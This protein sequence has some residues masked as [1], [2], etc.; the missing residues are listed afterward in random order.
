MVHDHEDDLICD[1][2]ETYGIYDYKQLPAHRVAILS[3]G[4]RE[5]S[6]I[7][8]K[9]SEQKVSVDTTLLAGIMDRVGLLVWMQ[10]RDGQKGKNKPNSVLDS[11]LSEPKEVDN[12]VYQSGEEFDKERNRL[13]SMLG[14]ND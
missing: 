4:L 12:V 9:M 3:I 10:T 14:G 11:L 2:A 5:T 1:L 13:L 8:M 7:K 6:R